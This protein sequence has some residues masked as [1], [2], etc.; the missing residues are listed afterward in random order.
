MNLTGLLMALQQLHATE[1]QRMP[2]MHAS[3]QAMIIDT[4]MLGA[5]LGIVLPL[6]P[7]PIT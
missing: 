2:R 7:H 3:L 6:N 4:S 5:N 1:T